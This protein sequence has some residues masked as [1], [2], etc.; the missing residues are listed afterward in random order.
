MPTISISDL[1]LVQL[2]RDLSELKYS[3]P[4]LAFKY[5]VTRRTIYNI[6][7]R[8]GI[9]MS[10]YSRLMNLIGELQAID[11]HRKAIQRE[12]DELKSSFLRDVASQEKRG[13]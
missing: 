13:L 10:S 7:W 12:V 1:G 6:A 3:V 2:K 9:S 4:E 8:S 5:G 11:D